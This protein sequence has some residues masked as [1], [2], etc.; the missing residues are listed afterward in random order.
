MPQQPANNQQPLFD[1][2]KGFIGFNSRDNPQSLEPGILSLCK[3][4]RLNR[5]I[6]ETRKGLKRIT[7]G[8]LE[9]TPVRYAM[10]F[11]TT[12][13]NVD[14]ILWLSD[15][16]L[17]YINPANPLSSRTQVAY[18]GAIDLSFLPA[19]GII[20]SAFQ[21]GTWIYIMLG[22]YSHP[23]KFNYSTG[24]IDFVNIT[25]ANKMPEDAMQGLYLSNRAIVQSSKDEI[26]VSYYLDVETYASLD[27]FK[28]NDGSDDCIVAIAPWVLNEFVIFMRN[29]IYYASFGAGAFSAG[30]APLPADSYVKVMATDIG[31]IARGSVAQAA[32]GMIFLSDGGVYM[33]TPQAATTP[34]G[35]RMGVMGEPLSAPIDDIIQRINQEHVSKAVGKYFNNRYYLAIPIDGSTVNNAVIIY[36]F[37]NKKW[38][39][40]DTFYSDM[41]ICSMVTAVT[42]G[43]R[44]LFFFD[45][46]YGPFLTEELA[47]G[48]H[49]DYTTNN[50]T[51][52][53]ALPFLL[54]DTSDPNSFTRFPIDS[55]LI[56]R[57]YNFGFSEDKRYSQVEIDLHSTASSQIQTSVIITNPDSETVIDTYGVGATSNST[58]DLPIR[59]V[60]SSCLFKIKSFSNQSSVRSLFITAIRTGNNIRSTK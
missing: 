25:G 38:E 22:S 17:Y 1:G 23:I 19:L 29:R 24:V 56:T 39:S 33:M 26:A 2:E 45:T 15:Q 30:D 4:F 60:G 46:Q 31:C 48:D 11:Q 55:E 42:N 54:Y 35:M 47:D 37:I 18:P 32:G 49:Y 28:I 34:E 44:R 40:I 5:G 13:D 27:V 14:R 7:P 16:H 36:N 21:A 53:E 12:E 8:G 51:L 20:P 59:K 10:T 52:P 9:N 58:R 3:N 41:D 57:S 43:K 50:N 6:A